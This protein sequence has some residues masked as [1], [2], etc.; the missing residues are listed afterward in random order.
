MLYQ[1]KFDEIHHQVQ[2]ISGKPEIATLTP[3]H[4]QA[5]ANSEANGIWT[6]NN[7][8]IWSLTFPENSSIFHVNCLFIGQMSD[9]IFWGWN[10]SNEKTEHMLHHKDCLYRMYLDRQA[11]ANSVDPDEMPQKAASHQGLHWLPSIQ[12]F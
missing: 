6:K 2:D 11:W 9:P 7:L 5:N 10:I 12:Q 3:T 1:C 4:W 8:S